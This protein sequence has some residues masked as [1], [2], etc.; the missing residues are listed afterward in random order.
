MNEETKKQETNQAISRVVEPEELEKIFGEMIT[1]PVNLKNG[2][3]I[4]NNYESLKNFHIAVLTIIF[5]NL[6]N[7]RFKKLAC[8]VLN[9]HIRKN[10]NMNGYITNE[11]KLVTF[12]RNE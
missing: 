4:L 5:N 12:I 1:N 2:H 10:W 9:I 3:N 7:D 11:E 6:D 8:S